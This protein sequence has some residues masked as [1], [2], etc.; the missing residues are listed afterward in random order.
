MAMERQ[1]LFTKVQQ[2]KFMHN[3]LNTGHQKKIIDDF[4]SDVCPVCLDK[5]ETWQHIFNAATQ[6]LS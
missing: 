5:E 6:A 4:A 2:V 1:Q 3:W